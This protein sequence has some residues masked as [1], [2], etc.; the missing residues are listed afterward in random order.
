[1]KH[2]RKLITLLLVLCLVALYLPTIASAVPINNFLGADLVLTDSIAIR[3]YTRALSKAY[4]KLSYDVDHDGT[5][6]ELI[7]QPESATFNNQSCHR[8]TLSGVTPDD[9]GHS[10]EVQLFTGTSPLSKGTRSYAVQDYIVDKCN[11]GALNGA[12]GTTFRTLLANLAAYGYAAE[13]YTGKHSL[14]Q[15]G[16]TGY[17]QM[18]ALLGYAD[19]DVVANTPGTS[20]LALRYPSGISVD[21][22]KVAFRT[23]GLNLR[24]NPAI[25]YKFRPIGDANMADYTLKVQIGDGAVQTAPFS[26]EGED[27]VCRFRGLDVNQMETVVKAWFVD[28]DGQ[29]ASGRLE[30]SVASYVYACYKNRNANE[31]AANLNALTQAL[32]RYGKTATHYG[33]LTPV[34]ILASN[35]V[36]SQDLQKNAG[37]DISDQ[38]PDDCSNKLIQ[39][40][41]SGSDGTAAKPYLV[42]QEALIRLTTADVAGDGYVKWDNY[43]YRGEQSGDE[44]AF[45][46]V[47]PVS[48]LTDPIY[49]EMVL[50]NEGEYFWCDFS[51]NNT[52]PRRGG[53]LRYNNRTNG[54]NML[55]IREDHINMSN[56]GAFYLNYGEAPPALTSPIT[57]CV[58]DMK[59]FVHKQGDPADQ[60]ILMDY[61]DVPTKGTIG[62]KVAISWS[63]GNQYIYD[64]WS[65]VGD[66]CELALTGND[67]WTGDDDWKDNANHQSLI[68]LFGGQIPFAS[69]G[70]EPEEV[71]GVLCSYVAW[72]KEPDMA[73]KL[74]ATTGADVRPGLWPENYLDWQAVL[75]GTLQKNHFKPTTPDGYT[76]DPR[77]LPGDTTWNGTTT[78]QVMGSRAVCLTSTPRVVFSHNIY[79]SLY[80]QIVDTNTLQKLL[81]LK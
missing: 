81:G 5:E 71:D 25:L 63:G 77:N 11:D 59:M 79:P 52:G 41:S 74:L 64:Q 42:S 8:F 22:A 2:I 7:L 4:L 9:M 19:T 61:Q 46:C 26:P 65:K 33:S 29:L 12:Y 54:F 20:K 45:T 35:G 6:D 53:T 37:L 40:D 57:L 76:S 15:S 51:M 27:Y 70:V 31:E 48:K 3:F 24:D 43:H 50:P 55:Q 32:L 23:V 28:G 73:N 62:N 60:W 30:Y 75:A 58:K 14:P 68:H 34:A 56:M 69:I 44:K 49:M 47:I 72:V 66:H 16:D 10:F 18:Q 38:I 67:L 80:D 13:D 36:N 1:M 78:N 21:T 39:I 17:D